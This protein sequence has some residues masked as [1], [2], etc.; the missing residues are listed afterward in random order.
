[1]LLLL[2]FIA[3]AIVLGETR[4]AL[5]ERDNKEGDFVSKRPK[6]DEESRPAW[7]ARNEKGAVGYVKIPTSM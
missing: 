6:K 3:D 4:Q 5:P 7:E 2:S 1:V